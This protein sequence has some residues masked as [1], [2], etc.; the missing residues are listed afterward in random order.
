MSLWWEQVQHTPLNSVSRVSLMC[1][2]VHNTRHTNSGGALSSFWWVARRVSVRGGDSGVN[3]VHSFRS[4][5][6]PEERQWGGKLNLKEGKLCQQVTEA[7]SDQTHSEVKRSHIT[8]PIWRQYYALHRSPF[9]HSL[10]VHRRAVLPLQI[11]IK[12]RAFVAWI[13][14]CWNVDRVEKK[15]SSTC[16]YS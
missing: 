10:S 4:Q 9:S 6:A 1:V 16:T 15:H 3:E 13:Y 12:H 2:H 7:Y 5:F 8:G 14:C 11:W